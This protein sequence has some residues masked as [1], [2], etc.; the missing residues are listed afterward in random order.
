VTG[1]TI[2]LLDRRDAGREVLAASERRLSPEDRRRHAGFDPAVRREQFLLGRALLRWAVARAIGGEPGALEITRR[3]DGRPRVV[4]P[5]ASTPRFSLSHSGD[6]VACAVH[7]ATAVGVDV[8]CMDATRD[9]TGIGA[10][11]FGADEQSWL[12]RQP[13]L[14]A[15]FYRLWTGREALTKL[16]G[17]LEGPASATRG[18]LVAHGA[19]AA[20]PAPAGG[21]YHAEVR[22]GVALSLMSQRT[23]GPVHIE[24][25]AASASSE[26]LLS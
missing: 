18:S 21:W 20:A 8:E 11:A 6:W 15:A 7:P 19:L 16:A 1:H 4:A 23:V 2:Y 13:A 25:V 24:L 12:L 22:P 3:A 5:G 17:E 26:L 14:S 10:L 9:L